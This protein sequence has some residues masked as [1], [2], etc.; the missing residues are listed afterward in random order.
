MNIEGRLNCLGRR[1]GLLKPV[2]APPL[3]IRFEGAVNRRAPS[4]TVRGEPDAFDAFV[5]VPLGYHGPL[6][7]GIPTFDEWSLTHSKDDEKF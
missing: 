2:E 1:L 6:P 7:K 5:M 4:G 3:V